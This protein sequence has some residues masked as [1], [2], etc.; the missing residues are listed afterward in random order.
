MDPNATLNTLIDAVLG[1][2]WDDDYDTAQDALDALFAW[3]SN[4]GFTPDDPRLVSD[5]TQERQSDMDEAFLLD[6][7]TTSNFA[8]RHQVAQTIWGN[9]HP[10][11]HARMIYIGWLADDNASNLPL[12]VKFALIHRLSREN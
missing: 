4:G 2:R 3:R 1:G 8:A 5:R 12:T 7:L 6:V 9:A 10:P 11:A